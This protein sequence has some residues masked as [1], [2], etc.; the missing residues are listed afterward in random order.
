MNWTVY[1]ALLGET[2]QQVDPRAQMMQ[3][4]FTF[5]IL[6]VIFYVVAIRP[7]SKKAK[8]HSEMMKTL[9]AGDKITTTGGV[10]GIVV[11][12]K[13]GSVTIRSADSKLEILKSAIGE[14]IAEKSASAAQS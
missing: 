1:K 5:I 2:T 14:V 13:D 6:G 8:E 10:V 11:S 9:K 12:V 3:M 4:I 7:Q